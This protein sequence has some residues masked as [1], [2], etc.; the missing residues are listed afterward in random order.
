MNRQS[1]CSSS[2]IND[3]LCRYLQ[4]AMD[5]TDSTQGAICLRSGATTDGVLRANDGRCKPSSEVLIRD[6]DACLALL[7]DNREAPL[8]FDAECVR[9][10][11]PSASSITLP[12]KYQG[13]GLGVLA[14]AT[15]RIPRYTPSHVKIGK[16]IASDIAYQT[17]RLEFS[18]TAR[19]A[20]GEDL[21]LVGTSDSLRRVDEFIERAS[22]ASLPAL[23]M[24]EF[25]SEKRHVAYALHF[26]GRGDYP[27][28]EV[29][30][31]TLN[32][33]TLA[34][35]LSDQLRRADGGTIFFDGIDELEYEVQG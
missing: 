32:P 5:A 26:G 8:V 1:T 6:C 11:L 31:A 28:V 12:I 35:I 14:L 16:S 4:E 24:G 10:A 23:I 25:G 2:R 3:L 7:Q 27:F 29:K 18:D 20:F 33:R 22:Q 19:V 13:E 9:C 30:C 17:K 15:A 21:M 34:P